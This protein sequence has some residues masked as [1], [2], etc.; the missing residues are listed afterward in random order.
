MGIADCGL[1]NSGRGAILLLMMALFASSC[2]YGFTPVGG[3]VPEGSRSIAVLSI[4]NGTAEPYVDVEVTKAITAEF[5]ADGRLKVVNADNADLL[6]KPG[7]W[8]MFAVK[9]QSI[10]VTKTPEA[11]FQQESK[12]LKS[13]GFTIEEVVGLEPYDKAHAMIVAHR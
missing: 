8:V 1:R 5:L 7:G 9:A 4:I 6:L 3:I 13:R 2:G 12:I 11:V 10:D